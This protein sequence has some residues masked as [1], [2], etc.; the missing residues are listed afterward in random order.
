MKPRLIRCPD[1]QRPCMDVVKPGFHA[2]RFDS[3]GVLRN[4]A[5]KEVGHA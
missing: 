1:C 4:C 5:W 2:V 3:A